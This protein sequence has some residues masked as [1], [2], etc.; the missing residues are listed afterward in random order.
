MKTKNN[1]GFTL[2]EI[3]LYISLLTLMI[4]MVVPLVV[5]VISTGSKSVTQQ[6][7]NT[8]TRWLAMRI[9]LIIRESKAIN[10]DSSFDVNLSNSPGAFLSLVD[11][12]NQTVQIDVLNGRVRVKYGSGQFEYL[13]SSEIV[14]TNLRFENNS[15]IDLKTRNIGI[16]MTAGKSQ[17]LASQ[18]YI[19]EITFQSSIELR[20][21]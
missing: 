14:V 21:E 13:S 10:V 11:V 2:I 19:G 20:N 6:I 8:E 17:E 9:G 15:S 4:S 16:F 3:L 18:S 12:T 7:L 1:H 5:N